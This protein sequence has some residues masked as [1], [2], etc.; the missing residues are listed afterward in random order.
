MKIEHIAIWDTDLEIMR[1]FYETY[2]NTATGK[3]IY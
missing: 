2:F 3:K 1:A